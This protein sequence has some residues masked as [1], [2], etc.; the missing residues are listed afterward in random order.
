MAVETGAPPA[1]LAK[2]ALRRL[3]QQR[4]EPTPDNYLRAYH[5]EAGLTS[6]AQ[7]SDEAAGSAARPSGVSESAQAADEQ[8]RAWAELIA[9]VVR[10]VE[11]SSRQWTSARRKDSLYRVLEGSASHPERLQRRLT[12]LIAS[13]DQSPDTRPADLQDEPAAVAPQDDLASPIQSAEGGKLSPAADA[14]TL[15]QGEIVVLLEETVRVALPEQDEPSAELAATLRRLTAEATA[16]AAGSP[17]ESPSDAPLLVAGFREVCEQARQVLRHRHHL[18]AQLATLTHELTDSL[19]DLAEDDSWVRGQAAAMRAQMDD[20]LHAR[21]VRRVGQLLFE[22]R[23]RQQ[24]VRQEREEARRAL[25]QLLH[26]MLQ[27]ISELGGQTDRFQSKLGGYVETIG[28]A[29]SL[30]SLASVVREMV[31]ESRA[32][33]TLVSQAQQRLQSEHARATELNDRVRELEDELR[34]LSDEVSTDPLTQVANR[35]GL[36]RAF[37]AERS[38]AER[39]GQSLAVALLDVDNFKRLND[40]LGHQVGDEALKFLADQ[41]RRALRPSDVLARYGGEEFVIL[42]PDSTLEEAQAALTRLQRTIS[43]E[44]FM[45]HG[46]QQVFITFSAG[47]TMHRIGEAVEAA[48]NRADIALYEAKRTGKNRT[49]VA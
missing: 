24:R 10:S 1:Q 15:A 6:E 22:T 13:W 17:A 42:L 3:A 31:E 39:Q 16:P 34:R 29:D 18:V 33:Q 4:L 38:R 14:R 19:G 49:C 37:E 32:V 9:R 44:L 8:G 5:A 12:Q 36:A 35:R 25:K 11:R 30:E 21:G 41:V 28:Q 40:Q 7:A 26:Q 46:E 48:L 2:A 43:A 23:M 27:E 45:S 47:V 20:G